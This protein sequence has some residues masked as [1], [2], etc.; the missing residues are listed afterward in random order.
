MLEGAFVD[1]NERFA[2]GS[3][4]RLPPG[5]DLAPHCDAACVV[6]LKKGGVARLR[7]SSGNAA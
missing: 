1:A 3:W 2:V 6:Y 7:A 4:L 5:D